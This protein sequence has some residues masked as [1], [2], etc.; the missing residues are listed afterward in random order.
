MTALSRLAVRLI[1][2]GF[3]ILLILIPG[4]SA[5]VVVQ[6]RHTFADPADAISLQMLAQNPAIR[7]LF[8][9]LLALDNAGGFTVW[10]TG[11]FAAVGL[12]T[13]ALLTATRITRGEE[14]SGRW[15]LLL[16][17]RLR[18]PSV[19]VHHLGVLLGAQLL[20]GS[21]LALALSVAGAEIQGL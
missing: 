17:G 4:L 16:T 20:L 11:T 7:V 14:Q 21:A 3:L 1:R 10:R 12:A 5:I 19:V 9:V 18:L 15:A 6:Y 8:G 2:R 13:W